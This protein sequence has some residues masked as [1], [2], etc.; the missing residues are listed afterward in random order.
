M[1]RWI[2]GILVLALA[3]AAGAAAAQQ[4]TP[5]TS[6]TRRMSRAA[7]KNKAKDPSEAQKLEV[8]R[9]KG[10]FIFAVDSCERKGCD[11][12]LLQESESGFMQECKVCAP[13][14]KCAADRDLIRAGNAKRNYN[15]CR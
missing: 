12:Q 3:T 2:P 7:K 8:A 11:E 5:S 14:E 4:S 9:L 1:K 15:P 10:V 13:E 6:S